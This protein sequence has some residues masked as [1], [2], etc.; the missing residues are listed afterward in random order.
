MD[1]TGAHL[2]STVLSLAPRL[3]GRYVLVVVAARTTSRSIVAAV[4]FDHDIVWAIACRAAQGRVPL[5][6]S[7]LLLLLL[8]TCLQLLLSQQLH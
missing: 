2:R 8:L 3:S 7:L 6:L 1:S 4:A 5:L